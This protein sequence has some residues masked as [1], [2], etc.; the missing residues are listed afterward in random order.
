M[1]EVFSRIFGVWELDGN[2]EVQER[3]DKWGREQSQE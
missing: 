3:V 2:I 1:G